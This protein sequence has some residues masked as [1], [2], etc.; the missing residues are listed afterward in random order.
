VL[1][2]LLSRPVHIGSVA[3]IDFAG[4][5]RRDRQGR[6]A[7]IVIP[8]KLVKNRKSER[9]E[10]ASSLAQH[11]DRH[12]SLF[13]PHLPGAQLGTAL[14][15]ARNGTPRQPTSLSR[16]IYEMTK[17]QIGIAVRPHDLRHLAVDLLLE[18]DPGAIPVAQQLLGHSSPRITEEIYHGRRAR[19]AQAQ[20]AAVIAS[21]VGG[22]DANADATRGKPRRARR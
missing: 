10:L 11:L 1:A 17:R 16:I 5:L 7:E 22:L 4:H 19:S 13:R 9:I 15:P 2:L 14:F 8:A 6:I 21:Q 20:Y 12:I 18:A 3:A